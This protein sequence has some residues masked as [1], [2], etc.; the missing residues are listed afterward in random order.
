MLNLIFLLNWLLYETVRCHDTSNLNIADSTVTTSFI[1][2]SILRWAVLVIITWVS[3]TVIRY[4]IS[5]SR[6]SSAI[7]PTFI[8][9]LENIEYLIA[10]LRSLW[11][12]GSF[13][14]GIYVSIA[15]RWCKCLVV[16]REASC[17][18]LNS[19]VGC[20]FRYWDSTNVLVQWACLKRWDETASFL[21]TYWLILVVK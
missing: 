7:W 16:S 10:V 17:F 13:L 2:L 4:Y 15:V 1:C 6:F 20:C 18:T 19:F 9:P 3:S 5:G 12:S 8:I 21:S 11:R 14:A